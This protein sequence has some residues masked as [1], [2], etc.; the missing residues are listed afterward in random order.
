MD[1]NSI[2]ARL[3]LHSSDMLYQFQEGPGLRAQPI[4]TPALQLELGHLVLVLGLVG[5]EGRRVE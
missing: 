4:V 1:H 5:R 2:I 3:P